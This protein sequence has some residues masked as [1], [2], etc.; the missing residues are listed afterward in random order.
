MPQTP[1]REVKTPTFWALRDR[2]RAF[3]RLKCLF[4][5]NDN[6]FYSRDASEIARAACSATDFS[7]RFPWMIALC[8][9]LLHGF[10]GALRDVGLPQREVPLALL[11]FNLGVEAGQLGRVLIN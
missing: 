10:S 5:T 4:F 8:L 7:I 9:N 1:P 2:S 6:Y 11:A 3:S